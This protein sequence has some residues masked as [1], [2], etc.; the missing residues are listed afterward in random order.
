MHVLFSFHWFF[1]HLSRRKRYILSKCIVY[2]NAY[3]FF[4]AVFII[5]VGRRRMRREPRTCRIKSTFDFKDS[6]GATRIR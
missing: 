6:Y 2:T 5:L 1:V 3:T 4:V